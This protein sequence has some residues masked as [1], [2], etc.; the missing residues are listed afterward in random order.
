MGLPLSLRSNSLDESVTKVESMVRE[1]RAWHL[2]IVVKVLVEVTEGSPSLS[3][4]AC[5]TAFSD[6]QSALMQICFTPPEKP[7]P[8]LSGAESLLVP[9]SAGA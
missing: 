5:S 3:S 8:N 4:I 1:R 2:Y 7:T 6:M 9:Y